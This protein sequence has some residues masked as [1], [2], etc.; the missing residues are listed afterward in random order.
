MNALTV[1]LK[2]VIEM[3]D[4]QF[5]QLCQN[6]RELRF[7]RNANGELIIMPPTGGETGNKNARITQQLMNWTDAD[8][9]GIAFDSSTC[10]KLPN[11]ADRSPDASWIKLERWDALTDEEKQKFPPICPD[12]VIE[13]LSPSDSLKVTQEKMQEY[14]DNGVGLGILINRKSRQVE[15]YRPGKEVEVLDSPATVSGEDVLKG[16][17]L[18]LGMIW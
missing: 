16:F 12:F 4:E 9:T 10:F 6:N 17:V 18:N 2:S 14:I 11:G 13:L 7:E 1:K 15:I 5:F 8:G 3:T